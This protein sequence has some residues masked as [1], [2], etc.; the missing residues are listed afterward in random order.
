MIKY[1]DNKDLPEYMVDDKIALIDIFCQDDYLLTHVEEVY[2]KIETILTK[3]LKNKQNYNLFD[4]G[5]IQY[6]FVIFEEKVYFGI[7]HII[8]RHEINL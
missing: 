7:T 6:S 8:I 1:T 5:K 3:H 4:L 2:Q